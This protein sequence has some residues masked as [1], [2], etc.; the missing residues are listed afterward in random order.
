MNADKTKTF[1]RRSS[2]AGDLLSA[3]SHGK[4]QRAEDAEQG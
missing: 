4:P 2:M 1:Y 3:R